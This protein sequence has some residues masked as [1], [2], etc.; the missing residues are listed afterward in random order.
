MRKEDGKLCRGSVGLSPRMLAMEQWLEGETAALHCPG[1]GAGV[2]AQH[3]EE[4]S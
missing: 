4:S 2:G 1:V 3:R